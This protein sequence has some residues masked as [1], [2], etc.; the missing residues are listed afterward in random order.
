MNAPV[1]GPRN[2]DDVALDYAIDLTPLAALPDDPDTPEALRPWTRLFLAL[3]LELE[4]RGVTTGPILADA[5]YTTLTRALV[6]LGIRQ[7]AWLHDPSHRDPRFPPRGEWP[8]LDADET[9]VDA[10]RGALETLL[11]VRQQIAELDE[12][13]AEQQ[14]ADLR[15]ALLLD[16]VRPQHNGHGH[17]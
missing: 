15:R 9:E 14:A 17:P 1:I 13:R 11:G 3:Q 10:V 8:T 6:A 4:P 7:A 5:R 12:Q 2:A 16:G